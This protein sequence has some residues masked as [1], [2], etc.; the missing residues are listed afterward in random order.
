[1]DKQLS[2]KRI[3]FLCPQFFG[4][5]E[6]ISRSMRQQGAVVD[7]YDE[8][9]ANS[10]AFKVAQRLSSATVNK[11]VHKYYKQIL[12]D[13]SDNHYDYILIIRGES[14]PVDVLK[15]LKSQFSE[16]SL[17]LYLW[18]SMENNLFIKEKL[19][20]FDKMYSFNDE[21]CKQMGFSFRPLFFS[22][23]YVT[24]GQDQSKEDIDVLF[25]GTV[26]SDRYKILNEVKKQLAEKQLSTYFYQY[27]PSKMMYY[28]KRIFVKEYRGTKASAFR[29]AP[30]SAQD[31]SALLRRSSTVIDIQHAKQS[32]LTMRTIEMLGA[33]KRMI[34][35]NHK[36]SYYDFFHEDNIEVIDRDA[37]E[38]NANFIKANKYEID[39]AIKARYHVDYFVLELLGIVKEDHQY[40]MDTAMMSKQS[41]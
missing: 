36:V 25:V 21:D 41:S 1:M 40:M 12:A 24:I 19:Q 3:L 20:Y 11:K 7:F 30:I 15:E 6:V 37:V 4:Y 8:R 35:T 39:E 18:D 27:V 26:H 16:A 28:L 33:N 5:H 32:G 29:F 10:V 31:I 9:P 23:D 34:T 13:I 38:I 22:D 17:I 14:I 2:N